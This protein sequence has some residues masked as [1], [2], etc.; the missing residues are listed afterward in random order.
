MTYEE[1]SGEGPQQAR[2]A[3]NR[4][5]VALTGRILAVAYMLG[6][7]SWHALLAV[8]LAFPGGDDGRPGL[9]AIRLALISVALIPALLVAKGESSDNYAF[10][11]RT[12]TLF[13]ICAGLP[14]LAGAALID[15]SSIL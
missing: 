15:I 8:A 5:R 1:D 13:L 7:T 3:R 10:K 12:L 11:R 9:W 14:Y 4:R 2:H 6:A